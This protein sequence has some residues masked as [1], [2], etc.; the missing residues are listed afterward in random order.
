V[1]EPLTPHGEGFRFLDEI[2][3]DEPGRAGR[4]RKWLD[5]A[6][7]FFA[8]H[9]PGTPI[10]PAVL[11][12]ECAAQAAGAVWMGGTRADPREPLFLAAVQ[13][14]RITAPSGPG[15]TIETRVALE[16]E[17]GTLAQFAVH[18]HSGSR[19]IARGTLLL[20]RQTNS[21]QP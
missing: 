19:E 15:E 6:S 8:A 10:M 14:F 7:S 5:P 9:F 2:E 3:I 20:S 18:L 17:L 16:K 1:N 11:L 13:S 12:I 4:G 21:A